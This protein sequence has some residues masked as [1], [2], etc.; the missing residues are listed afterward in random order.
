MSR[1]VSISMYVYKVGS[2]IR[3][4]AMSDTQTQCYKMYDGLN[5]WLKNRLNNVFPIKKANYRT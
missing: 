5:F 1:T 2:Q 3:P 4:L